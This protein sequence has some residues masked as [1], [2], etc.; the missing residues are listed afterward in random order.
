MIRRFKVTLVSNTDPFEIVLDP[1]R[2]AWIRLRKGGSF[3]GPV[4]QWRMPIDGIVGISVSFGLL[5]V[6]DKRGNYN[7]AWPALGTPQLLWLQAYL[8]RALARAGEDR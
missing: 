3:T 8:N 4:E 6:R 7:W 1:E 5:I 2:T